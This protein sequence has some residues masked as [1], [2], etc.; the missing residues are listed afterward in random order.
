MTP[1]VQ[2]DVLGPMVPGKSM[3]EKW[4][5]GMPWKK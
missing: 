3:A 5:D 2:S 4:I 1:M